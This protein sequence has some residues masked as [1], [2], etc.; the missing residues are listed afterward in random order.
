MYGC[1]ESTAIES[2]HLGKIRS[3]F[4]A[5]TFELAAFRHLV[6]F[7]NSRGE[8]WNQGTLWPER[9]R[10][11]FDPKKKLFSGI[12]LDYLEGLET[13]GSP[14]YSE[15]APP[16][17]SIASIKAALFESPFKELTMDVREMQRDGME[18]LTTI[19]WN[20]ACFK[21]QTLW[22]AEKSASLPPPGLTLPTER[23]SKSKAGKLELDD[24]PK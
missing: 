18:R 15:T 8:Q 10:F 5:Q 24:M 2:D 7:V 16:P 3:P 23:D 22:L 17:A 12:D 6:E 1:T 4:P 20:S 11:A 9:T 13:R 14:G 19:E 21:T